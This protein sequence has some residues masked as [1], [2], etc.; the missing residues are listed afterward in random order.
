MNDSFCVYG[1]KTQIIRP[2]DDLIP[3]L[4]G[5]A[6]RSCG[7]E[8]GDIL[9]IAETALATAEGSITRLEDVVPSPRALEFAEAYHMDPRLV[10]VVLEESDAVIGGIPGFLLS[11]KNGTLLPNAG[12][13]GSNAPPGTVVRLPK[14]PDGSAESI[15]K[16]IERLCGVKIGVLIADSRTHAMRLGCGGVAIGCSGIEAVSDERGRT[17]LYGRKLE[18]TK[19]AVADNIV[20]AS[21]LIMG[22]ADECIP[23]T[24]VRGLGLP[25]TERKGVESIDASECLF[26]GVALNTNPSLFDRERKT[27]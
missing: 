14:D 21:E 4:L 22:E 3:I 24:L 5:S 9:V 15:R 7:L 19:G 17:D 2:G 27:Q 1:L 26:M 23:A 11:M 20:S 8:K 25:I 13:D 10:E 6:R 12:I 18:V 16:E